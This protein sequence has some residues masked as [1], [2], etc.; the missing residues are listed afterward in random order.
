MAF[1][2][3][4]RSQ[5]LCGLQSESIGHVPQPSMPPV[6]AVLWTA[7]VILRVP[8]AKVETLTPDLLASSCIHFPTPHVIASWGGS[9]NFRETVRSEHILLFCSHTS[10]DSEFESI[11]PLLLGVQALCSASAHLF[12]E[13]WSQCVMA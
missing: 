8:F 4:L 3:A 11:A 6:P 10:A 5:P 2:T 1:S 13:E 12:S 9:S 7:A